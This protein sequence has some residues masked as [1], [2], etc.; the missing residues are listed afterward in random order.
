MTDFGGIAGR[1]LGG[2]ANPYIENLARQETERRRRAGELLDQAVRSQARTPE[3]QIRLGEPQGPQSVS[4]TR[5]ASIG[6]P[7]PRH[8]PGEAQGAQTPQSTFAEASRVRPDDDSPPEEGGGLFSGL[9]GLY[10]GMVPS[11]GGGAPPMPAAAIDDPGAMPGAA[12]A[13][14]RAA[15][16]LQSVSPRTIDSLT[17][18][19]LRSAPLVGSGAEGIYSLGAGLADRVRSAIESDRAAGRGA[20]GVTASTMLGAQGSV[21]GPGAM[22]GSVYGGTDRILG[23]Q[24]REFPTVDPQYEDALTEAGDQ[25][26]F[27]TLGGGLRDTANAAFRGLQM[28]PYVIPGQTVSYRSPGWSLPQIERPDNPVL[29]AVRSAMPPVASALGGAGAGA[30]YGLGMWGGMTAGSALDA[31]LIPPEDPNFSSWIQ[32]MYPNVVTEY[33]ATNPEDPE[34]MNRTRNFVEAMGFGTVGNV[35]FGGLNRI[36]GGKPPEDAA[37]AARA[38]AERGDPGLAREA[39]ELLGELPGAAPVSGVSRI[40]ALRTDL[41][42]YSRIFENP[43]NFEGRNWYSPIA[44]ERIRRMAEQ[45]MRIAEQRLAAELGHAGEMPTRV[46]QPSA[47]QINRL[48]SGGAPEGLAGEVT[49]AISRGTLTP[50]IERIAD[51]L[52]MDVGTLRAIVRDSTELNETARANMRDIILAEWQRRSRFAALR[53]KT[54]AREVTNVSPLWQDARMLA[55]ETWETRPGMTFDTWMHQLPDKAFEDYHR[56]V[57]NIMTDDVTGGDRIHQAFGIRR[58]RTSTGPGAF[59][60]NVSPGAQTYTLGVGG[61]LSEAVE[62]RL[63]AAA[64]TRGRLLRQDAVAWHSAIPAARNADITTLPLH[65]FDLGRTMTRD[66]ATRLIDN[67]DQ[68]RAAFGLGD[69]VALTPISTP[70]GFRVINF[71]PDAVDNAAFY[72]AAEQAINDTFDDSVDIRAFHGNVRSRYIENDWSV[73]PNGENFTRNL[74]ELGSGFRAR[75][76]DAL[77]RI[78]PEIRAEERR[79]ARQWGPSGTGGRPGETVPKPGRSIPSGA[80]REPAEAAV[81]AGPDAG[82]AGRVAGADRTDAWTSAPR[83]PGR[84]TEADF[85]AQAR[86]QTRPPVDPEAANAPLVRR[87]ESPKGTAPGEGVRVL[88]EGADTGPRVGDEELLLNRRDAQKLAQRMASGELPD[89]QSAVTHGVAQNRTINANTLDSSEDIVKAMQRIAKTYDGFKAERRGIQSMAE[90]RALADNLGISVDGLL[91]RQRGQ[92]FN[93]PQIMAAHDIMQASNNELMDAAKRLAGN[94]SEQNFQDFYTAMTRNAAIQ[95]Q[96]SGIRAEAGRALRT[97]RDVKSVGGREL[98]EFMEETV[99]RAGGD[100]QRVQM[101]AQDIQQALGG[102]DVRQAGSLTRNVYRPDFWDKLHFYRAAALLSG[103]RTHTTNA[104]GNTISM[105]MDDVADLGSAMFGAFSRRADK[106]YFREVFARMYGQMDGVRAAIRKAGEAWRTWGMED[107]AGEM[108]FQQHYVP[109]GRAG[110]LAGTSLRALG[111]EDAFFKEIA[112]SGN[113]AAEA[114]HDGIVK[115][116]RGRQLR[117]YVSNLFA[118]PTDA[119][120]QSAETAA[121]RATFQEEPYEFVRALNRYIGTKTMRRTIFGGE[122]A[123]RTPIGARIIREVMPFRNTPANLFRRAAEFSPLA[124]VTTDFWTA[125][126]AGGAARHRALARMGIGSLI[127]GLVWGMVDKGMISGNGP[128]D[129]RSRRLWLQDNQP[130]SLRIGDKWVSF[131]RLDPLSIWVGMVA[132]AHSLSTDLSEN[133]QD[134]SLL[135]IFGAAASNFMDKTWTTGLTDMV[136]ALDDPGRFGEAFAGRYMGSYIPTIAAHTAWTA[137][138][139]LRDGRGFLNNIMRRVPGMT[140]NVPYVFD[141]WGDPIKFE[142]LSG[143]TLPGQLLDFTHAFY[144]RTDRNDPVID[145]LLRL[146]MRK[147]PPTDVI[148]G[149]ELTPEQHMQYTRLANGAVR[150]VLQQIVTSRYYD[151]LPDATKV[152][153]IERV[154]DSSRTHARRVMLAQDPELLRAYAAEQARRQAP[155][156]VREPVPITQVNVDAQTGTVAPPDGT[157]R[158]GRQDVPIASLDSAQAV[159]DAFGMHDPAA[160]WLVRSEPESRRRAVNELAFEAS[161]STIVALVRSSTFLRASE[162]DRQRMLRSALNAFRSHVMGQIGQQPQAQV[163]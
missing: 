114:W 53:S 58:S 26:L 124:G 3:P 161:N 20:G 6:I 126:K 75:S 10:G 35:A 111:A 108:K 151:R 41:D 105:I 157:I 112:R 125:F 66:E 14:A 25:F 12:G 70:T 80:A 119:M 54:G 122:A 49:E 4:R 121:R 135:D 74:D 1:V 134:R 73:N 109:H 11:L 88:P 110:R 103:I 28:V 60:G 117:D 17:R 98:S 120:V 42:Y 93:A 33:L 96:I 38:I 2:E 5:E 68:A 81:R 51:D 129:P 9:E 79:L 149:V 162:D 40:N 85:A 61:E 56:R 47:E 77:G 27:R 15:Q 154:L 18:Q 147:S 150:P 67:F 48:A 102:G 159:F 21:G 8:R 130:Y 156:A 139:Y 86:G 52:G 82:A 94:W 127:G 115:G 99:R 37:R 16:S 106:V 7:Q 146:D 32:E 19:V 141:F 89:P 50:R 101:I 145:E 155:V 158:I 138:P 137:D 71:D 128:S 107:L 62:N 133:D 131:R 39:N 44:Q 142:G 43:Q 100:R 116:Y 22:P 64:L 34:W 144:S 97:L 136:E 83:G 152:E 57:V 132:D 63:T 90:T 87:G 31:L 59:E 163:N 78:G 29:N 153:L 24:G 46:P 113:F 30:V 55:E 104:I 13:A 92:A 123:M 143:E 76:D 140:E 91:R 36:L 69:D 84:P 95:E 148:G 72:R 23:L 160:H 45:R 118:N 65:H